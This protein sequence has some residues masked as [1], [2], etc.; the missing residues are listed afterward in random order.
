NNHLYRN[1]GDG[2]FEEVAARAGVQA[3]KQ[4]FAKGCSWLD[5]DNDGF[6][7]LFVNNLSDDARLYHNNR[8][9]HFEEVTSRMGIDGPKGFSCWS[10]DYDNEGGLDIFA[11]Y[12]DRPVDE[13]IQGMLGMPVERTGTRLYR[14]LQGKGFEDVS[15]AAGLEPFFASMGSNYA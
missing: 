4:R 9:G 11:V 3:D 13:V 1:R 12:Y 2:T 5:Y 14:T 8:D 15:V 6:R 7:D 10:F